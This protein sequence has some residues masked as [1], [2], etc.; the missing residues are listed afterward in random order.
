MNRR[1]FIAAAAAVTLLAAC[2]QS[3]PTFHSVDITGADYGRGFS[4]TDHAGQPRTLADYKGKLVTLFFGFTHCPDVCPTSLATMKQALDLLG[5][6][7]GKVQVLFVTVDPERDTAELL[8]NYVPK[9][10]PSFVGLRGDLAATQAVAKEYKVFYQKVAGSTAGQY[11]MDHSAGTYVHDAEG[12]LRLF[13]RH[14]ETPQN[15]ADDLKVLL[16]GR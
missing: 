12:R 7:A 15:I 16:A 13:I 4:L 3:V 10:D 1:F 5:D 2:S 14:G 8:A 9:F 11:S 6:D